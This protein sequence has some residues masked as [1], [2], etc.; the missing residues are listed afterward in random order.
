MASSNPS[1]TPAP[2]GF[3]IVGLGMIADFHAQAIAQLAG[4][5][6]VG[7]ATRS[8]AKAAAFAAKHGVPFHTTDLAA[9]LA[10]PGLDIVCITT[11]SAAHLEPAL[12][13]IRAGKHLVVEKPLEVD[14]P[15][16]DEILRAAEVA[17]VRIAPIFQGRFGDGARTVKA[18]LAAGRLG[19][20]VL[21]SNYVKW[22]RTAQYY[23]P[24]RGVL[25]ND[26]G[27]AV[28]NQAIHGLDLLLWFVGLPSEVAAWSTR[29]VH[30]GIE[31]EDTAV[32]AL[33]FPGGALGAFEAT[34]AAW[35]GWSRRH[36]L[37]GEHGSIILEDDRI[38]SWQFRESR[39]EDDAIRA[40]GRANSLGSGA[41]SPSAISA[42]GHRRQLQDLVDAI[43]D[44]RPQALD[45]REGRKAVALV[46]A[47]YESAAANGKPVRL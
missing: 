35:P 27:G 10:Q 26:G 6:L 47:L 20:L 15:R 43:R 24:P 33:T 19:R 40:A 38:V 16:T 34:T 30:T 11:P 2:L 17:G 8:P 13:A 37:C 12:A 18:A 22:H 29:R 1:Q 21:A 44:N 45:G 42:E 39:P 28:I 41:S 3:G 9:L 23:T 32:A 46:R 36:E 31:V 25:A 14:L 7:V 4:A 5:R